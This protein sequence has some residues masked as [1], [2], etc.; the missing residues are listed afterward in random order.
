MDG[1]RGEL[2]SGQ[3]MRGIGWLASFLNPEINYSSLCLP[4]SKGRGNS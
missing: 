2:E 1:F 3:T 4:F